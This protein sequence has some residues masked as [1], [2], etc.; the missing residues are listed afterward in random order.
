MSPHRRARPAL[1]GAIVLGLVAALLT[2]TAALAASVPGQ[3]GLVSFVAATKTPNRATLTVD[4]A[5]VAGATGYNVYAATTFDGVMKLTNP[6]VTVKGSTA[7]V[8][9]LYQGRDY[10]VTVQ[11]FNAVGKGPRSARV[12]HGTILAE[13]AAGSARPMSMLTWNV[14]SNVCSGIASRTTTINNRILELKPDLVALQEAS[15][16]TKRPTGYAF[17]VNG[18]NDIMV[19]YGS[20][21][22]VKGK[23][24][25][26]GTATFPAKYTSAGKGV[27][28]AALKDKYGQYVLVLSAHLRT[29]TSKSEI[30]Q[31][32]SET[33]W[34]SSFV[35][36]RTSVLNKYYGGLTNWKAVPIVILGDTNTNKSRTGDGT[37]AS[38][39]KAGYYDA[40]DQARKLTGQHYN[41]A[42]PKKSLTPVVGITWGDH[43]DKVLIKPTKSIVLSWANAA[44]MK[45]G[46]YVGPLGS[47]H[48]PVLVSLI[49]R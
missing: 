7:T 36:N 47:D 4:W 38:L 15:K 33:Q 14:C 13:A 46:K 22:T 25:T 19:R 27:S 41:T 29:G 39:E 35:A 8:T 6:T 5:D 20:Y 10:F 44:K 31:R 3:V 1:V 21:A 11:A 17:V 43:V 28:W 40:F 45:S 42:T 12:G 16:Y 30:A 24:P 26:N 18:Q 34:L 2:P 9:G 23:T 32:V 48:Q 37:L 49:L